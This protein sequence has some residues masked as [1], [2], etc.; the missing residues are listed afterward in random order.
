[1]PTRR[2]VIAD[3]LTERTDPSTQAA[4]TLPGSLI[5]KMPHR[6]PRRLRRLAHEAV[7]YPGWASPC[8]RGWNR[9]LRYVPCAKLDFPGRATS[10]PF[11]AVPNGPERT[12]TDNTEA[13]STNLFGC[14]R[15]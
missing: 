15:R 4:A 3:Q 13:A 6:L 12:T 7:S 8:R 14:L 2:V 10:V 11:T 9:G 1:M 5:W